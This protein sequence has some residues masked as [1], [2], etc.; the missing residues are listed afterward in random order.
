MIVRTVAA[1]LLAVA[2]LAPVAAA[3]IP[4]RIVGFGDSLIDTGNVFIATGGYAPTNIYNN[5]AR[6]YFPGRFTNGPDYVDLLSQQFYGHY[7]APSLAGG[8][9]YAFGGARIV[10]DGDAVPDLAAQLGLYF[11]A[12]GNTA[13][14]NALYIINA[15]G[16]D[17][18]GLEGGQIGGYANAAAYTTA[19]LDTLAGSIQALAARGAGRILVTGIPNLDATGLALDTLVQARLDAIQPTLGNTDLLRFSYLSFFQQL[20]VN[21]A[22]LGVAPFTQTGNCRDSRVAVN[23]QIDCTGFF[24]F[25]GIHPTAVVQAAIY[26]QIIQIAGVPEPTTWALLIGGFGMVGATMRQRRGALAN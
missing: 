1:V 10:N 15:G 11:A 21:P 3:P 7:L 23:G 16:N 20:A 22:S 13:D 8:S 19:L 25:D 12:S 4:S 5:P 26:R 24:S 14:A 2:G 9:N 18:F 6:G 17:V